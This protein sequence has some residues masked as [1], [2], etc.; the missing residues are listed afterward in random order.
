M[1]LLAL[2]ALAALQNLEQCVAQQS[3]RNSTARG[4]SCCESREAL[5]V[6]ILGHAAEHVDRKRSERGRLFSF[7][8]HHFFSHRALR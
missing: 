7:D 2:C 6:E 8:S 1:A 3:M 4:A 5:H